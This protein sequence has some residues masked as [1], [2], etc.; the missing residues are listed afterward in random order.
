MYFDDVL[1]YSVDVVTH[2][3]HLRMLI[4]VLRRNRL[5]IN[6]KKCSF[7][8]SN[9]K[10]LGF[11][12]GVNG[13]PAVESKI[14]AIKEWPTPMTMGKVRSFHGLA[15]LYKRFIRGFNIIATSITECLKKGKFKWEEVQKSKLCFTKG[16]IVHCP[17]VSFIEF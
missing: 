8:Q 16:E 14:K 11:I 6:L 12:V 17:Y 10:F 7:L 15:T 1:V 9:I 3:E 2:L 4:E 13:I 5:H